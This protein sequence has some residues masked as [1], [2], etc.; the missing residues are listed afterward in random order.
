MAYAG[1]SIDMGGLEPPIPEEQKIQLWDLI[2]SK[3]GKFYWVVGV[4]ETTLYY[5]VLS[6]TG[7]ILR[8][9]QVAPYYAE[10]NWRRVGRCELTRGEVEWFV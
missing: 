10:K 8:P 5:F 9:G 2:R 3:Q 6:A 7:S 4:S 1:L